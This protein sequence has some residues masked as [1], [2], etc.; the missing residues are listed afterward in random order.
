MGFVPVRL[1]R[2]ALHQ[3]G[4]GVLGSGLWDLFLSGCLGGHFIKR[5][6]SS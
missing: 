3:N 6:V 5:T 1:L 2:R 4:S